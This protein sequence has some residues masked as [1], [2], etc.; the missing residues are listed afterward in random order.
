MGINTEDMPNDDPLI[1]EACQY[2]KT[3][4]KAL[5][6]H[7]ADDNIYPRVSNRV[8]MFMAGSPGAGKTETSKILIGALT[9]LGSRPIVRIDADEIRK[10]LP[11]YN[12]KNASLLQYPASLGVEKVLDSVLHKNQ[13]FILDGT[14]SNFDK[15]VSNIERSIKKKS[16]VAVVYVY[17][18]PIVAW[19]FTKEREQKEGRNIPKETFVSELFAAKDS[20]NQL[21]LHFGDKIKL[22]LI[23]RDRKSK[24]VLQLELNIKNIDDYIA[25]K[26]SPQDLLDLLK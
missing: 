5:I 7:F 3:Q 1:K 2:I 4:R 22:W 12:G 16:V 9:K 19:E 18:D 11:G 10:M 15:A 25:I 17:Q 13:N 24:K 8:A 23:E 26:Y 14:L 6:K 20:V 21:K